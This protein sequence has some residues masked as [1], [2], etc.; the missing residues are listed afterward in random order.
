MLISMKQHGFTV[1]E[2]VIVITLMG[3]L[4][5]LGTFSIID[6]QS[7]ARDTE[8]KSDIEIIAMNLEN[9]YQSGNYDDEDNIF[10]KGNYP[11][12][13]D[14]ALPKT[15]LRDLDP[16]SLDSPG[17]TGGKWLIA[18]PTGFP[19]PP[20]LPTD[21]DIAINDYIY[22]PLKNDGALCEDRDDCR[23]FILYAW[24]EN[25]YKDDAGNMT[26]LYTVESKNQ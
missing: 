4:M 5:G 15:L 12:T 20:N 1:V 21:T 19:L 8:R 18:A 17:K 10:Q 22:L 14:M 6:S 25:Q 24:L 16:K 23:K 26:N 3:I 9:L 11:S 13:I 7:H 2:L